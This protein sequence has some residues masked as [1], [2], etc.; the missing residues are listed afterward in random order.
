M[1]CAQKKE[2]IQTRFD[3]EFLQYYEYQPYYFTAASSYP[4]VPIISDAEPGAIQP[5]EW[6]LVPHWANSQEKA[7]QIRKFTYNARAD[8]IFEKPSFRTAIMKS[9]CLVISDGWFEWQ[10]VGGKKYPYY[11][12]LADK[13]PFAMAGI[14]SEWRF[15]DDTRRTFS[16]VT[17]EAN[18]MM[19]EIHNSGKRMPVIL[20]REKERTWLERGLPRAEI[21][22][23]MAP[24]DESKMMAHTLSRLVSTPN[25]A[26]NVPDAIV[27]HS[28]PEISGKAAQRTLF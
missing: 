28:Y 11:I 23:L 1:S 19:A 9:R 18:P 14:W 12:Q 15:G 3:A 17:T 2:T 10:H 5:M 21:E 20:P 24:F 8:T 6:S 26:K 27:P 16:I 4:Q 25:A 7:E 22:R 13:G